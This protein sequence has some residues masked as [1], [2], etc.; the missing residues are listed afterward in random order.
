[1][2]QRVANSSSSFSNRQ[3]RTI[4]LYSCLVAVDDIDKGGLQASTADKETINIRLLRKLAAVLLRHTASVQDASLLGGVRR[5][6]LLEP[7][8]NGGVDFLRLLG[9][10]YFA[11][12]DGPIIRLEE[13]DVECQHA[14]A[15]QMGS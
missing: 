10:R 5:D 2:I 3:T 7:L 13:I 12:A 11:G 8:A 1:V 15:Y 14:S 6:L 4:T 9:S